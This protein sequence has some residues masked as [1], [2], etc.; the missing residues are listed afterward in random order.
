[1][2]NHVLAKDR[3]HNQQK[4]NA[5]QRDMS[6]SSESHGVI[7]ILIAQSI[8]ATGIL[9][10]IDLTPCV[11]FF[12]YLQWISILQGRNADLSSGQ[13]AHRHDGA[14][15]DQCPEKNH[16]KSSEASHTQ[17]AVTCIA[18]S[19]HHWFLPEVSIIRVI[20][21]KIHSHT[22]VCVQNMLAGKTGDYH[23]GSLTE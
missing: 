20:L 22:P 23:Q 7:R 11:S 4:Q 18:P 17:H 15:N 10:S 8:S 13:R 19:H 3:R 14:D 16:Y 2:D 1:M 21:C 5:D 12:E 9:L 6:V